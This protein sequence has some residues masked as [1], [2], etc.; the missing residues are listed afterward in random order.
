MHYLINL[1]NKTIIGKFDDLESADAVGKAAKFD[2]HVVDSEKFEGC[3][4][5]DLAAFF[6]N[7][8]ATEEKV[9]RFSDKSSAIRR[10]N[11]A[12]TKTGVNDMKTKTKRVR[13]AKEPGTGKSKGRAPGWTEVEVTAA[14][15]SDDLRFHREK[16]RFKVF[17]YIKKNGPVEREALIKA[18]E[19]MELSRAQVFSAVGKLVFRKLAKIK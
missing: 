15:K 6:N 10:I 13:K 18:C 1:D 8:P 14:G 19:K 4:L 17:E 5:A 3:T 12:I 2:Y 11:E 16:P 9:T 7:L